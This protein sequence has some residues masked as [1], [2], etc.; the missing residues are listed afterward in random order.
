MDLTPRESKVISLPVVGLLVGLLAV[1]V[2]ATAYDKVDAVSKRSPDDLV[3]QLAS[4]NTKADNAAAA[5]RRNHDD[6]MALVRATQS[7]FDAIGPEFGRMRQHLHKLELDQRQEAAIGPD[8]QRAAT[9]TTTIVDQSPQGLS[10]QVPP[11]DTPAQPAATGPQAT[12]PAN[13]GFD[14]STVRMNGTMPPDHFV[15]AA[16]YTDANGNRAIY[17][18]GEPKLLT[19]WKELK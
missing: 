17:L 5:A 1:F 19:V 3:G 6:L 8:P 13:A 16:V 9:T 14:P 15:E 18:G 10:E 2:A 11:A 4:L 12:S 7:A